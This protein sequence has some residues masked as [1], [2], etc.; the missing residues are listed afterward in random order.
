M[1]K[2]PNIK[3]EELFDIKSETLV[4]A[5]TKDLIKEN[6]TKEIYKALPNAKLAFVE[7]N[8]F[9]AKHNPEEFNG[10]VNI[11]LNPK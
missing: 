10:K 5:G 8:H 7:G 1:V 2:D 4:I 3:A 6:H 11:F 9:M